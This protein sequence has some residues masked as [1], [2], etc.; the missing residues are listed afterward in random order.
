M[1]RFSLGAWVHSSWLPQGT[2]TIGICRKSVITLVG[3]LP[4]DAA[5]KND[6]LPVGVWHRA[7][8]FFYSLN[9]PAELSGLFLN[10]H[11]STKK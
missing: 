8:A 10:L 2:W 4:P 7:T 6:E 3:L 5:K 11:Q 9:A 1:T